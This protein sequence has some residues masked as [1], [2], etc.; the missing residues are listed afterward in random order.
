MRAAVVEGRGSSE[1]R[2][3]TLPGSRVS[4]SHEKV[5][6]CSPLLHGVDDLAPQKID[7]SVPV[8][9]PLEP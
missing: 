1:A 6:R 7:A 4:L 5:S 9:R 2:M 3:I 8:V